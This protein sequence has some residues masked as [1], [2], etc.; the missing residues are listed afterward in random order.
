MIK[1]EQLSGLD[2]IFIKTYQIVPFVELLDYSGQTECIRLF[3][4]CS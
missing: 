1:H 2:Q 3:N 4:N